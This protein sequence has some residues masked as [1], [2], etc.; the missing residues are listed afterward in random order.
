MPN[1]ETDRK[2]RLMSSITSPIRVLSLGAG[3]NSIA[4]IA[5][6]GEGKLPEKY[7]FTLAVMADSDNE[8]PRTYKY[9]EEYL[10]PCR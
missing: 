5:L 8:D 3:V 7:D 2:L 6:K 9:I 4:L 1:K 10:K